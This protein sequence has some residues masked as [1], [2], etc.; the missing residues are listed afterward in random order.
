MPHLLLQ[1]V[2]D[3]LNNNIVFHLKQLCCP[4]CDPR[5]ENIQLHLMMYNVKE[6][7]CSGS[8]ST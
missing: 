8:R 7:L 5:L 4:L 2:E 3:E 6:L 1:L